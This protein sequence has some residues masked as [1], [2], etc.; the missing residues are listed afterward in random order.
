MVMDAPPLITSP[1]RWL[2]AVL[3]DF[4]AFLSDHASCE[5][6]A[7]GMALNVAA[8]YPDQPLLVRTMADLAVEELSHYREV[9]RVMLEHGLVAGA[10]V[11]DPYVK[12]MQALIRQGPGRYLLD[13]LLVAA[14]IER[15]GAERF[16]RIAAA[17]PGTP[18]A[19]LQGF[20][21]ALATSEQRH[22]EQ[23]SQLAERVCGGAEVAPR[24]H[25]LAAHEN[26][27]MLALLPRA[28]LH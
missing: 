3:A 26:A 28:A 18:W 8:H 7:S 24:L 17:L 15:R 11:R 1:D 4:P 13:R 25:E 10:D 6:K 16:A 27:I 2:Q 9:I 5:K 12:A 23:F 19:S 22:W 21:S 20:Y 14:L